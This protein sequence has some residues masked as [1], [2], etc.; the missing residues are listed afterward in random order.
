M[1]NRDTATKILF[2]LRGL[3]TLM[4]MRQISRVDTESG[5]A[6]IRATYAAPEET[7]FFHFPSGQ[8]VHC[9][10]YTDKNVTLI[11]DRIYQVTQ[12]TVAQLDYILLHAKELEALIKK[13]PLSQIPTN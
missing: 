11:D 5:F 2:M 7:V 13:V 10:P 8:T 9:E 3:A 6:V 1:T 12:C 4:S